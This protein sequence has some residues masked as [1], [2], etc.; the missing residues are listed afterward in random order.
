MIFAVA[1]VAALLLFASWR[2]GRRNRSA[3][4][5]SPT[6]DDR[7]AEIPSGTVLQPRIPSVA[8]SVLD[9]PAPDIPAD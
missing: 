7:P 8:E 5:P 1:I 3:F 6:I 4:Y 9:E 2:I